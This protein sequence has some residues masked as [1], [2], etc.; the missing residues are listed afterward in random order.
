MNAQENGGLILSHSWLARISL[1]LCVKPS[2][3][4]RPWHRIHSHSPKTPAYQCSPRE[5]GLRI[6]N[7]PCGH[8]LPSNAHYAK[9]GLL[10]GSGRKSWRCGPATPSLTGRS[11]RLRRSVPPRERE[12]PPASRHRAEFASLPRKRQGARHYEPETWGPSCRTARGGPS[13]PGNA[14]GW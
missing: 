12:C 1:V 9:T 6:R 8:W 10:T 11:P 3:G 2:A 7:P 4:K 13:F 5:W 14:Q